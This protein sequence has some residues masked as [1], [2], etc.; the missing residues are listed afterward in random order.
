MSEPAEVPVNEV[1]SER[2]VTINTTETLSDALDRFQLTGLRHLVVIDE[3]GACAGVVSDRTLAAIWPG[4]AITGLQRRVGAV[5]H[6]GRPVVRPEDTVRVAAHRMLDAGVD[7]LPVVDESD[8]VVGIVTGSDLLRVL[9]RS[10]QG[11][12]A[13]DRR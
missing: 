3:G 4:V 13:G 6:P 10:E 1:M 9:A 7:A 5:L 11:V 2:L 12:E 8:E